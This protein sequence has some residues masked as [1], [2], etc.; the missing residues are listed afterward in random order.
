LVNEAFIFLNL[1]ISNFLYCPVQTISLFP[2]N[3]PHCVKDPMFLQT[4]IHIPYL[5]D[6]FG[7]FY[8]SQFELFFYGIVV[9]AS[10]IAPFGGFFA[11]GLKRG[12]EMKVGL[13]EFL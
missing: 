1:S 10:L 8:T 3:L 6:H 13:I 2:F 7:T 9:Y 5:S 11:S 4:D 12:L